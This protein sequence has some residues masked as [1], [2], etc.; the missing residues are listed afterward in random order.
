MRVKPQ[1][2]AV[3]DYTKTIYTIAE[4]GDVPT[5]NAIAGE[6]DVRPASVTGMLR[7]L[8]AL[9]LIRYE[10]YR[11]VELTEAGR[12]IALEV[13]RHHRLIE[14]FLAQALGMP[15]DQVHEEAE[16]L[17]HAISER[18]EDRIAEA[19]GH[20]EFD[21]HG[22]PIPRRDGTIARRELRPLPAFSSGEAVR[23]ARIRRQDAEALR[24]LGS[25]GLTPGTTVMIHD[26]AP[27]DG[28]LTLELRDLGTSIVLAHH[29]AQTVMA[30]HG[31]AS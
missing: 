29:M 20:P 9:Q 28:P 21:P 7:K 8:A 24:Y 23:I 25:L 19:L 13:I 11:P 5:T 12:R 15:W 18:L 22:D 14:T 26:K 4:R 1:T 10:P 3:E 31:D 6:L 17:E 16:I 30:E 27:L 2:R